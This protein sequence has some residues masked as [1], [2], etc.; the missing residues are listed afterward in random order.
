MLKRS[1]VVICG[2]Y[3]IYKL[4]KHNQFACKHIFRKIFVTWMCNLWQYEIGYAHIMIR[5]YYVVGNSCAT[6]SSKIFW[7]NERLIL[8]LIIDTHNKKINYK[9]LVSQTK[10][11]LNGFY[12]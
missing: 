9:H 7:K 3:F 12:G 8:Y 5:K 6:F 1:V 2:I 10:H 4:L 11:L